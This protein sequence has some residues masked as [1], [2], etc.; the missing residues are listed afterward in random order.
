MSPSII[1]PVRPVYKIA[2]I[3]GDGIG[4]E[5]ISAGIDVLNTLAATYGTFSFEFTHFDWS[6]D[7]YLKT[8]LYIPEGGLAELK[9]FDAILF[10]AVGQAGIFTPD[11]PSHTHQ[12]IAKRTNSTA[13]RRPRPHI[14]LGS[15]PRNMPT[16]RP[17]RQRPPYSHTPRH[18]APS[19]LVAL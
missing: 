19:L 6:S 2:S 1:S 12:F 16:L 17:I 3:P 15:P 4:T 9:K 13:N 11:P 7:R 18:H 10:G 8:G 5:V 14:P